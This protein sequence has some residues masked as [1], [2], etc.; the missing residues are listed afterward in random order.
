MHSHPNID[1]LHQWGFH[2]RPRIE[3]ETMDVATV[4][5]IVVAIADEFNMK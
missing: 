2:V 5:M 3:L 1:L 4:G